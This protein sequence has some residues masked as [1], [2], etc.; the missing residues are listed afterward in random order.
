[1]KKKTR[2]MGIFNKK[3]SSESKYYVDKAQNIC[4]NPNIHAKVCAWS[5]YLFIVRH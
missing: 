2:M 3:V 4:Y 5:H 1:M